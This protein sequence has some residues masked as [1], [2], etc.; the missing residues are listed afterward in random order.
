MRGYFVYYLKI[1]W[2]I[3]LIAQSVASA[4]KI[5]RDDAY[6][7][8][9]SLASL[10]FEDCGS[11]YKVNY[12]N[13]DSCTKVPC[14]M[15]RDST[16]KVTVLFDDNGSGVTFLKHEVRWVFTY[17][18]SNA[19]ITPDP[20]DGDHNCLLNVN[21]GK[22]YW[23]NIFVNKTLPLM[24]GSMLWEAKNEKNENLICFEVPVVITA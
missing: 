14:S 19:A 23:A 9:L 5:S 15:A 22:S 1:L 2:A 17:V 12:L 18:K 6:K 13:I 16:V 21:D 4:I 20:C 8:L 7:K 10:P 24:S 3:C 11:E